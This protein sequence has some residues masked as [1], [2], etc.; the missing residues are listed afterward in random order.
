L[1]LAIW[2]LVVIFITGFSIGF[3]SGLDVH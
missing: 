1:T 3:R 2:L